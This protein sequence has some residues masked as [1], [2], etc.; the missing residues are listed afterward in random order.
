MK[1]QSLLILIISQI[2][3]LSLWFLSAAMLNDMLREVAVSPS[4]QA[5]LS[6][7][8][9]LGF[10]VGALVSAILGLP[11]RYDPRKLFAISAVL[12]G[13]IN[14]TL[15]LSE[16]GG[17]MAIFARFLTGI[18]LA[19]VYPVGMKIAVSWGKSDRAFL[20]GALVGALTIGSALPHLFVFL[21][22]T[23]W[24]S[25][26]IVASLASILAGLM[27]LFAALGPHHAKAAEF[28]PKAIFEA[29]TNKKVRLAYIGYLA[30]IW[31]LYAMWTWIGA[32]A[33]ASYVLAGLENPQSFATLTAFLAIGAGGPIC[34][35]AGHWGD[36]FGKAEVA[37]LAMVASGICALLAALTFG[38]PPLLSFVI[39]I[40]WGIA[41]IP[42][43]ALFTALVADAA[44][45]D[46]AGSLMTLQTALGFALTFFTVQMTPV[47]ASSIGWPWVLALMALGP[48]AGIVA[49]DRLRKL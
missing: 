41:I 36:R 11:D 37:L 26:V 5:A 48:L 13:L 20:V 23:A 47:L 40:A 35:I 31:E 21:G 28:N 25:V 46:Q 18:C 45:A 14:A 33:L 2:A 6:S 38:G 10:V 24:R 29:W 12:A 4:R 49:M 19:G 8:V 15:I 30:H 34:L 3:A 1:R 44:P 39:F 43:S 16:P 17:N 32:I 27:C 22:G 7:A 42:D 9:Q